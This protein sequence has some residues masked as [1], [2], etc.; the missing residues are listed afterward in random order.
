VSTIDNVIIWGNHS[1]TQ[2]PDVRFATVA[3]SPRPQDSAGVPALLGDDGKKWA[4]TDFIAAIQQRGKAV[5]DARG[6]SSAASAAEA[7]V[8]HV[9][10]WVLGS[11][12]KVVS[13]GACGAVG[14]GGG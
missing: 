12:G 8:Q 13:M 10:D 2:Y 9:R 4:Q 5:I 14:G 3:G 6:A 11:K 1:T 7:S